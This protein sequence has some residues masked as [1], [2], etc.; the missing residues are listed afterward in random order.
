LTN[1]IVHPN[2]VGDI[3]P[4]GLVVIYKI[5]RKSDGKFSSGG[6]IPSFSKHGKHWQEQHLRQH[7]ALVYDQ[8]YGRC[9]YAHCEIV[10]YECNETETLHP[11]A[12]CT[13]EYPFR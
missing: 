5:R 1:L 2:T 3:I 12:F 13:D 7:M 6:A 9:P 10:K 11:S 8:F 4:G